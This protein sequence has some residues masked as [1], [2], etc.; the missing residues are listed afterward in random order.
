V[1]SEKNQSG[2]YTKYVV[3]GSPKEDKTEDDATPF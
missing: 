2:H 1:L 3:A